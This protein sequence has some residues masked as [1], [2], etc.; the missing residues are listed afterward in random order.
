MVHQEVL[1]LYRNFLRS[2]K[3]VESPA[4]RRQLREWIQADFRKHR[5]ETD[6]VKDA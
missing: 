6:E 5:Y 3:Q 2:I 1:R 4:D